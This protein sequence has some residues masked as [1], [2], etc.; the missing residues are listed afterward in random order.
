MLLD[1]KSLVKKKKKV[2]CESSHFLASYV[3]TRISFLFGNEICTMWSLNF[4][5]KN[6]N[7][8]GVS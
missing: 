5:S 7:G 6:F 8:R 4:L 2:K 3:D 1:F